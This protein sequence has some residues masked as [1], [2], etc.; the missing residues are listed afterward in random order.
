MAFSNMQMTF[1]SV[2]FF[3]WVFNL[4]LEFRTICFC[5]FSASFYKIFLGF[6]LV[7]FFV[8]ALVT[9][10]A[11]SQLLLLLLLL[12]V[13]VI[14]FARLAAFSD[15]ISRV[16]TQSTRQQ[17]QLYPA[18]CKN[19]HMYIYMLYLCLYLHWYTNIVWLLFLFNCT[20]YSLYIVTIF[21]ANVVQHIFIDLNTQ[22]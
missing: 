8:F 21:A 11:G 19:I 15:D 22:Q 2:C 16:D 1:L 4:P 20:K 13:T 5:G 3:Q 6:C 12:T 18:S 17:S 10:A 14:I 9:F 7:I